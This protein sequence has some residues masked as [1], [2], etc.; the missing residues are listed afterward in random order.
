M[1]ARLF[2]APPPELHDAL[3][4]HQYRALHRTFPVL[5]AVSA[6]NFLICAYALW[7]DGFPTASYAWV[8]APVLLSLVRI[9]QWRRDPPQV[10]LAHAARRVAGVQ[11]LLAVVMSGTSVF[12]TW[13]TVTH[14]FSSVLLVPISLTFGAL[15][16]AHATASMPLAAT[17]SVLGVVPPAVAM[18]VFGDG[19]TRLIGVSALSV[20]ALQLVFLRS[21]YEALLEL[22]RLQKRLA[23]LASSD[24]LTGL[25][26]R[27]A[28]LHAVQERVAKQAPFTLALID[29]DGFKAVNDTH[30]HAMGDALLRALSQRFMTCGDAVGRLGGDE[31]VLLL[32]GVTEAA[33]RE[34]SMEKILSAARQPVEADGATLNVSASIGYATFPEDGADTGALMRVA[35]E[36]MYSAKD[37][38]KARAVRRVRS[39]GDG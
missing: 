2:P 31:F 20:V 17:T 33:A 16:L 5:H 7:A 39:P 26:S 22:L 10:D 1:L 29:L 24:S 9:A 37:S 27:R 4:Q 3:V 18:L 6:L 15:C 35:D 30:G 13:A 36:A 38:G 11:W 23:E 14:L 32:D 21:G 8:A 19:N 34:A 28:L 25:L 12:A